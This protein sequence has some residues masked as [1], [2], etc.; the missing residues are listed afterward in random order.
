MSLF[1]LQTRFNKRSQPSLIKDIPQIV[2]RNSSSKTSLNELQMES[3]TSNVRKATTNGKT[4]RSRRTGEHSDFSHNCEE[5]T[6]DRQD[7]NGK[8]LSDLVSCNGGNPLPQDDKV[9][10]E[11]NGFKK[12]EDSKDVTDMDIAE[13]LDS[14]KKKSKT[15]KHLR[16]LVHRLAPTP[17]FVDKNSLPSDLLS[18]R[19]VP[20]LASLNAAAK[21]NVFFE[22]SSPLAGRSLTDIMHHSRKVSAGEDDCSEDAMTDKESNLS[23]A[24]GRPRLVSISKS[25]SNYLQ[26]PNSLSRAAHASLGNASELNDEN[27]PSGSSL[28]RAQDESVEE[29]EAK[30]TRLDQNGLYTTI[31]TNK[32]FHKGK[33]VADVGLQVEL[34]KKTAGDTLGTSSN[35]PGYCTCRPSQVID[36]PIHSHVTTYSGSVQVSIPITKTHRLTPQAPNKPAPELALGELACRSKRVAGLNS[37]AM[38]NAILTQ[39]RK[40]PSAHSGA[41]QRKVQT[42]KGFYEHGLSNTVPSVLKIPKINF[43]ATS[44]SNFSTFGRGKAFVSQQ[45]KAAGTG[46]QWPKSAVLSHGGPKVRFT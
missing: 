27:I 23:K 35:R 20:R 38:L 44:T 2:T 28:K 24:K 41:R 8:F 21:V 11:L 31:I 45:A 17:G 5:Q 13:D 14:N 39:E 32:R 36:V 10:N 40:L 43:A 26:S 37:R 1:C 19:R 29:L 46:S 25:D 16:T 4:W 9:D 30:R 42:K 22:P 3:L 33:E 7:Q 18:R 12:R 15:G 6:F 34:P